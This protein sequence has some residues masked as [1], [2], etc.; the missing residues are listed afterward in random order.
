MRYW[1]FASFFNILV[2]LHAQPELLSGP[3]ARDA[4][5]SVKS[6]LLYSFSNQGFNLSGAGDTVR[7]FDFGKVR[8]T[9]Q[10][11]SGRIA[12]ADSLQYSTTF[13]LHANS[14]AGIIAS[15][16][17]VD[18]SRGIAHQA[19]IEVRNWQKYLSGLEIQATTGTGI[20]NHSHAT[21]PGWVQ[22]GSKWY[23]YGTDTISLIEAWR[24]GSYTKVAKS[25]DSALYYNP[26]HLAVFA[27]GNQRGNGPPTGAQKFY[28]NNSQNT[29]VDI[30]NHPTINPQADGGTSGFDCLSPESVAKNVLSIGC[31]FTDTNGYTNPLE[32]YL[33]PSSSWGPTDDGRIKPDLVAPG[34]GIVVPAIVSDSSYTNISQTSAATAVVSGVAALLRGYYKNIYGTAPKSSTLKGLLIHTADRFGKPP[35]YKTG[36]GVIN[37][38]KAASFLKKDSTAGKDYFLREGVLNQGD[39]IVIPVVVYP[40]DSLTVTLVYTDYFTVPLP[41]NSQILNNRTKRLVNDLDLRVKKS[42]LSTTYFPFCGD[43]DNPGSPFTSGDN[44]KDNVEQVC[45]PANMTGNYLIEITHKDSLHGGMQEFTLLISGAKM[46]VRWTATT[47]GNFTVASNWSTGTLPTT[48]D[49]VYIPQGT[50]DTILLDTIAQVSLLELS[51]NTAIKILPGA[52]LEVDYISGGGVLLVDASAQHTAVLKHNN[53]HPS[54]QVDFNVWLQAKNSNEG[55]WH[56]L[57]APFQMPVSALHQSSGTHFNIHQVGGGIYFWNPD[58]GFYQAPASQALVLQ[59]GKGVMAFFG[60]NNFGTFLMNLP[61]KAK[62]TGY[63]PMAQNYKVYLGYTAVPTYTSFA[64]TVLDGW[65]LIANPFTTFYDWEGQVVPGNAGA[66]YLRNDAIGQWSVYTQGDVANPLRYLPPMQAFWVRNA[67]GQ[68]DSL[69]FLSSKRVNQAEQSF[70]KPQFNEGRLDLFV[71]KQSDSAKNHDRLLLRLR[72]GTGPGYDPY[73]DGLKLTNSFPL[74]DLYF[75]ADTPL[76]VNCME[77]VLVPDTVALK[78]HI[79]QSGNYCISAAADQM[80][81][82]FSLTR[83]FKNFQMLGISTYCEHF[84]EGF[85]N[86]Y[87]LKNY[88]H[89]PLW[90]RHEYFNWFTTHGKVVF[91]TVKPCQVQVSLYGLSGSLYFQK[92]LVMDA[93]MHEC[94]LPPLKPG[95]YLIGVQTENQPIEVRKVPFL[96]WK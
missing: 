40:G 31:I 23:W 53:I 89:Q 41:I 33:H 74:P 92:H 14:V 54:V 27:V 90:F 39:T 94:E 87:L 12:H 17:L 66:I 5:K 78:L 70:T 62:I 71:W 24:F 15:A 36:F 9:H 19:V 55:R 29:W 28:F 72:N 59:P 82:F 52:S 2:I 6:N 37:A 11:L 16:G 77:Q 50:G 20:S 83:D 67:S 26:Y 44:S 69:T 84:S 68:A 21:F 60:Q 42:D 76:A 81:L 93:G 30:T 91:A 38:F 45:T 75:S 51:E 79:R 48:G 46:P 88:L 64:S 49:A 43:P 86:L 95:I 10:E 47:S 7:I 34:V 73:F 32:N 85:Y 96:F 22:S 8:E 63:S 35:D 57:G 18:S 1:F 13:S 25:I 80:P 58:T 3:T 65:N 4:G 56:Y 61:G